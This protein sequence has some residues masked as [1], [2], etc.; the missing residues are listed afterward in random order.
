[1]KV[2][3]L[4][5]ANAPICRNEVLIRIHLYEHVVASRLEHTIGDVEMQILM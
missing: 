1:M 5:G 3:D 4:W 2:V